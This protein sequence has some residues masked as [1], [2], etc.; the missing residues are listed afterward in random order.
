MLH[1]LLQ[2]PS[3]KTAKFFLMDGDVEGISSD[4]RISSLLQ[5]HGT[6]L[7]P[8][9]G[10][11]FLVSSLLGCSVHFISFHLPFLELILHRINEE[12]KQEIQQAKSR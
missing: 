2:E 7:M 4:V 10:S 1:R 8:R 9:G 3:E 6:F 12:E 5:V 11:A